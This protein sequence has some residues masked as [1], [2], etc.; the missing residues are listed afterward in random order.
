[1]PTPDPINGSK[2]LARTRP[3]ASA[4]ACARVLALTHPGDLSTQETRTRTPAR[5]RPRTRTHLRTCTHTWDRLTC[6]S[7]QTH[8]IHNI[9][10]PGMEESKRRVLFDSFLAK[11]NFEIGVFP[12]VAQLKPHCPVGLASGCNTR[13]CADREFHGL[14]QHKKCPFMPKEIGPGQVP[15]GNSSNPVRHDH[16][17]G[18]A[19]GRAPPIAPA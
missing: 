8:H 1:M 5:A 12:E 16:E 13:E 14:N 9:Q 4:R 7:Q 3:H 19:I 11:T 2:N 15:R 17:P 10:A 18:R 6:A